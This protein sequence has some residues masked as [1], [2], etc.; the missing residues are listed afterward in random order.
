M[1]LI[2]C[3]YCWDILKLTRAMERKCKC[4]KS[5]GRCLPDGNNVWATKS[6]LVLGLD[7]Y[8]L[9]NAAYKRLSGGDAEIPIPCWL[10]EKGYR[11]I[12]IVDEPVS[13]PG[14]MI[15]L[16]PTKEITK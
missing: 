6:A 2:F 8:G 12:S 16:P 7:N 15:E 14:E 9:K 1:K 10:F 3:P 5:Q 4:G 11:K 13:L